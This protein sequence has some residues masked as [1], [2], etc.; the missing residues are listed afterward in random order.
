MV[1]GLLVATNGFASNLEYAQDI[2]NWTSYSSKD[3]AIRFYEHLEGSPNIPKLH[4]FENAVGYVYFF[5]KIELP[6]DERIKI[7]ED[8]RKNPIQEGRKPWDWGNDRFGYAISWIKIDPVKKLAEIKE[9]YLFSDVNKFIQWYEPT[10]KPFELSVFATVP[11]KKN[12][13]WVQQTEFGKY[14]VEKVVAV[15]LLEANPY[16]FENHT[17]AARLFFKKMLSKNSASFHS[18]YYDLNSVPEI[19]VSELPQGMHFDPN[20]FWPI[21]LLIVLKGKGTIEGT[22]TFGARIKAPHFQYIGII[23]EDP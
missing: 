6:E 13:K 9:I 7:N 19:I 10:S 23:N 2:K 21:P 3:G 22:N 8:L 17:I 16:E 4:V 15:Y 14:G 20:P 18:G 1:I 12:E 5:L 11:F